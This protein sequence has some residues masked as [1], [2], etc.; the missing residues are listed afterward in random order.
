MGSFDRFFFL[1]RID[2]MNPIVS[3]RLVV[4][5]GTKNACCAFADGASVSQARANSIASRAIPWSG[6]MKVPRRD[7]LREI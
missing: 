7:L 6:E 2:S 4:T 5:A 3:V 1:F